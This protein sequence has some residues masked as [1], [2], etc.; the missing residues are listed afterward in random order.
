MEQA[1]GAELYVVSPSEWDASSTKQL[2]SCTSNMQ[3]TSGTLHCMPI[4]M[5]QRGWDQLQ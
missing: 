2:P 4:L 3:P 1:Q 5:R